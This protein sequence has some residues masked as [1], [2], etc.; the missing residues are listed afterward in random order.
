MVKNLGPIE[1]M[2]QMAILILTVLA[3]PLSKVY[4]TLFTK[5]CVRRPTDTRAFSTDNVFGIVVSKIS[6]TQVL[7]REF[8]ILVIPFI[9]GSIMERR[10]ALTIKQGV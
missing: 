8:C 10:G 4:S 2:M 6:K 7:V 3:T 9:V 1:T 5:M